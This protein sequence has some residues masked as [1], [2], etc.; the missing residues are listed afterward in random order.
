MILLS[1]DFETTGLNPEQDEITEVGAVLWS[2]KFHRA[3]ETASFFVQTATHITQE[4]TDITGINSAMLTKFGYP[5]EVAF[6]NLSDMIDQADAYC[7][8]NVIRFDKRFAEAWAKKNGRKIQ[9]KLW[10]DTRTDLPGVESKH[11][12]YMAADAGF[13]NPFPHNAVSD[14]LTVLRLIDMHDIN[15]VV[16]RAKQDVVVLRSHQERD[17]NSTAKKLGFKWNP[18]FKIWWK[19]AKQGDV[20]DIVARAP[21]NIS[22][23]KEIPVE[24]LW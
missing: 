7:G 16:A 20:D 17:N 22:I 2:T 6:E 1:L 5:Q 19:D 3:M 24:R 4:I 14:C 9:E 11:L 8:Q 13:L 12:G 21:F 15:D 18:D 23:E 10:I